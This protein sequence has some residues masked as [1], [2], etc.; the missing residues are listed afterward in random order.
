MYTIFLTLLRSSGMCGSSDFPLSTQYLSLVKY[1]FC[2]GAGGTIHVVRI[3]PPT[4][5]MNHSYDIHNST[6]QFIPI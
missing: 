3:D 1:P 6:H 2:G 5:Q 4:T